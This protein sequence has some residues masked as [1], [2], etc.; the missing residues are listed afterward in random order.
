[1][2]LNVNDNRPYVPAAVMVKVQ[3]GGRSRSEHKWS[4]VAWD[5]LVPLRTNP[6]LRTLREGEFLELVA[7]ARQARFKEAE[8]VSREGT[9][10]EHVLFIVGGRAKAE[11]SSRDGAPSKAVVNILKPGDA[12]G[13]LSMVD[14]APHSATVVALEEMNTL[15]VPIDTMQHYLLAHGQWYLVLA[16]IAVA[17]L[18]TSTDWLQALI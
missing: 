2:S 9:S 18:R 17:Q 16:E 8:V 5:T 13:L 1:M 3:D 14:G 4:D 11:V 15:A 12:I 10:V 6:L 7:T